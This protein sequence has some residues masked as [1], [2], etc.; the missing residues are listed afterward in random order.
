MIEPTLV[1][2]VD[3]DL[4]TTALAV[5]YA[6]QQGDRLM[7]VGTLRV[8]RSVTQDRAVVESCRQISVLFHQWIDAEIQRCTAKRIAVFVEGQQI[9]TMG[10]TGNPNDIAK[11]AQVA[12]AAAVVAWASCYPHEPS[13]SMPAPHRWKGT[14]PKDIHQ[15]RICAWLGFKHSRVRKHIILPEIP[16]RVDGA[17]SLNQGDWFHVLDAVGIACWGLREIRNENHR[18]RGRPKK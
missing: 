14:V 18:P 5:V 9:Y 15:A 10:R 13:L 2:G 6:D 16:Y 8:P 12:G 4:H 7:R 11:L 3:P 1:I 17:E